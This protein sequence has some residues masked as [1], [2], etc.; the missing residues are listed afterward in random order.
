M[1][2]PAL[3]SPGKQCECGVGS[4]DHLDDEQHTRIPILE[5]HYLKLEGGK[6]LGY[7]GIAPLCSSARSAINQFGLQM[8]E[9]TSSKLPLAR[10]EIIAAMSSSASPAVR[11]NGLY[12]I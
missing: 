3:R 7:Y 8:T 5:F 2:I 4:A 6:F 11:Q 10:F 12:K 1:I 9:K